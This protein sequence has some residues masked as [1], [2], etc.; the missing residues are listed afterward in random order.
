MSGMPEYIRSSAPNPESARTPWYRG[1]APSYAGIF[2]WVAFY[3]GLAQPNGML[4][5]LLQAGPFVCLAAL[6]A[7]G[8]I[9]FAL[10]YYAPAM[11][12]MRTGKPLY[13][14]AT[15][16]FGAQGGY[17]MPGLLMGLLQTGWYAVAT[18][19]SA[20][21][22]L[23]GFQQDPASAR[24]AF[25]AIALLWAY[26]L[27]WVAVKG[28]HYV[29]RAARFIN[30]VP[31]A[32]IALVFAAHAGGLA[33]YRTPV[34]SSD[35]LGGFLTILAVVTGYFAT[36]GAAGADF[37]MSSRDRRDVVLGGLSG[38]TLA[39]LVAGGLPLLAVAGHMGATG[40]TDTSFVSAISS[41][42]GLGQIMFLLFAVASIAPTCFCCFVISTCFSTMLPRVPKTLSTLLSVTVA[43]LLAVSGVAD[44]LV[45]FFSVVG[46]S[47]GPICGAMAAE[48]WLAKGRFS[49]PRRGVN[50][51][52]F[53]AWAI[54]FA[55]GIAET[56]P[57]VPPRLVELT[58][59]APLFSFLV[60]FATYVLLSK[61]G[62]R[63]E[64]WD[65]SASSEPPLERADASAL[66]AR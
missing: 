8:L 33:R 35:W 18:S 60:G 59:P 62:L 45:G 48:Y 12:G 29:A 56:L 52:G 44:N 54:G 25:I 14:V 36:A 57:G 26:G 3:M 64:V 46:A 22:V 23:R 30:W 42:G 21:F 6:L 61:L 1:T 55:I 65:A 63:T 10:Y 38:I 31:L 53:A 47:F 27:A 19:V 32:M 51:P 13:V 34:E 7:A 50:W 24:G 49:G 2:L 40:T 15:Q 5:P 11:F 16:T 41:V 37:G 66:P 4:A 39:I 43:A 20:G 17:V 9:C 28:L 58:R